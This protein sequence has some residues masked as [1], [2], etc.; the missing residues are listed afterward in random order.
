VQKGQVIFLP[1][2]I[3]PASVALSNVDLSI[4][5][6]S[7][8]NSTAFTI[9][10]NLSSINATNSVITPSNITCQEPVSS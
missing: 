3:S 6:Q 1:F 4:A 2:A 7:A 9:T 5:V 8:S 10:Y